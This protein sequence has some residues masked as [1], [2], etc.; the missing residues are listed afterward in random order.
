MISETGDPSVY[1]DDRSFDEQYSPRI[2]KLSNVHWSPLPIVKSAAEF[3]APLPASTVIDIGSGAGKFCI[4][5][6]H[7]CP[8]S[9]F[10]GIEQRE[11]LHQVAL[12]IKAQTGLT[13]VHFMHGNFTEIKLAPYTGI[14]FY[15]AFA[16]NLYPFGRIDNTIQ[17][18]PSLY[19]YYANYLFKMLEEKT[20]GTRLATYH[21]GKEEVPACY[22]LQYSLFDQKLKLW[23]RS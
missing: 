12:R 21:L 7:H 9:E 13:N 14:Y 19:N 16:E 5:A 4:A 2:Q 6:A 10:H 20:P 11:S 23:I 15:N 17:Y 18:S 1:L 3:L 8:Q 22:T